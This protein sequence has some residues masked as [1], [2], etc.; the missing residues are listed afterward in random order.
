MNDV[1]SVDIV[2]DMKVPLHIVKLHVSPNF[3]ARHLPIF[4]SLDILFFEIK[5]PV[6]FPS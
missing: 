6:G 2:E 4:V 3:V 5:A 1:Y